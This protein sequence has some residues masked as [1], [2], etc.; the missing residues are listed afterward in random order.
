MALSAFGNVTTAGNV[1]FASVGNTAIT[2]LSLCNYSGNAVSANVYAVTNGDSLGSENIIIADL[3]LNTGNGG[4]A[5]G[6]TYQLYNA[7][8]KLV[9]ANGES[10]QV[11]ANANSAITVVTSYTQV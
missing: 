10:I 3:I 2:W 9:L 6:D 1:V 5:G 7:A 11:S 8:E 4:G